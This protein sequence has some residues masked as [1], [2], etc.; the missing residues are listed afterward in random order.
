MVEQR[1]FQIV[2]RNDTKNAKNTNLRKF[3]FY[4]KQCI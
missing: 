3:I 1:A 4:Q 2:V